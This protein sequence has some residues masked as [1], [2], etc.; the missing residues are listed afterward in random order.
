M[1]GRTGGVAA[2]DSASFNPGAPPAVPLRDG[3][4]I[5]MFKLRSVVAPL[6]VEPGEGQMGNVRLGKRT[7]AAG[8][9]PLSLV[10]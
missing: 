7:A 8:G 2:K 6:A 9:S 3:E 4:A 10:R 5:V 1:L